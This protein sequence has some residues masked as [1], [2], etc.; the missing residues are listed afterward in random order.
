MRYKSEDEND[1]N[2]DGDGSGDEDGNHNIEKDEDEEEE[3]K[4]AAVGLVHKEKKE[5]VEFQLSC[6]LMCMRIAG[7]GSPRWTTAPGRRQS[8]ICMNV[9]LA[10]FTTRS[11]LWRSMHDMMVL[12]ID[13]GV[14]CSQVSSCSFPCS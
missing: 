1:D 6:W 13:P 4:S 14:S 11:R 7:C 10:S 8:K 5:K 9:P 12:L 3:E 2:I